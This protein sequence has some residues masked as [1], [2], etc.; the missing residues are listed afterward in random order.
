MTCTPAPRQSRVA[1]RVL[2]SALAIAAFAVAVALSG[3][4]VASAAPAKGQATFTLGTGKTGKV[5]KQQRVRVVGA[6]ATKVT[7]LKGR[8]FRAVLPARAVNA[9]PGSIVLKGGLGFKRGER[10][11][12]FRGLGVFVKGKSVRVAARLAG[13]T[14]TLF[15]GRGKTS[16]TDAGR[17]EVKANVNGL[18]LTRVGAQAIKRKLK[19]RGKVPAAAFGSLRSAARSL[20]IVD[21][22]LAQCG[23]E[24]QQKLAGTAQPA[25][26]LPNMSGSVPLADAPP[27]AW[28]FKSGFR[29]Y[30]K[31][32]HGTLFALDG[33]GRSG[34]D[35]YDGFTF[36]VSGG[37]YKA[38][39]P[40]DTADDQ[41]VIN[42]KGTAVFC[43]P[44][45]QFRIVISNPTLV[46]D[47]ANSRLIADVDTNKYGQW[48]PAQR[49]DLAKL[50]PSGVTPF[51]NR[52]GAEVTWTDIPATLTAAGHDAFCIPTVPTPN[53]I[54]PEGT[55]LDPVTA[56]VKTA[57]DTGKGDPAAWTALAN[58]VKS[59]LPFP[60]TDRNL[61]GC[62]LPAAAGGTSGDARTI[63]EYLYYNA[64]APTPADPPEYLWT[65]DGAP[66]EPMPDLTGGA[67]LSG[68]SL[69]WGV[70]RGL[71]NSVS[72]NGEFNL[73]GGVAASS[74]YYG[75]GGTEPGPNPGYGQ[76]MGAPNAYFKWPSASVAGTYR[77]EDGK[78][79][80]ILRTAGRV[81]VCNTK[82][83]MPFLMGYGTVI[84]D[85]TVVIDGADSR[86]T[87]DVATRYRLSWVRGT[88]D[89]ARF[90]AADA[91]V[92]ENTA[93][94]VT[95]VKWALPPLDVSPP[96]AGSKTAMTAGGSSVLRMLGKSYVE[97]AAMDNPTITIS[98]PAGP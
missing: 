20:A 38:N 16:R 95:T 33:A 37:S 91:A 69:D 13:G 10:R 89:V 77:M 15:S 78:R 50:D 59:G 51:F 34:T 93:G 65:A 28:G 76:K 3:S 58:Y 66:A 70:V 63:D 11:V 55:P 84:S 30:L 81:S 75:V 36:P 72:A 54:Y 39:G 79:Q 62:D 96:Y 68:G 45:H 17:V 61:G 41:A 4:E 64:K 86:I 82:M 46:I 8:R 49:V 35:T 2:L 73:Y 90:D 22:Y 29:S 52:S 80:L 19:L 98:F 6:G 74:T 40:V 18:K 71:R 83:A 85:P 94:G 88:V 44:E 1:L 23:L 14:L 97:G 31:M 57:Y 9:S 87:A 56:K 43:N 48:T 32:F 26:P 47:G 60:L 24:V 5:L 25:A 7:G 53:C 42:G 27:I 92:T 21:P 67:P 12:M